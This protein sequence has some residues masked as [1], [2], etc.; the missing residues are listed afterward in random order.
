MDKE[1]KKMAYLISVSSNTRIIKDNFY[2]HTKR[3]F[4]GSLYVHNNNNY[5]TS[6]APISPKRIE[7]SG[8]PITGVGQIRVWI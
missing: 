3:H 6:I 5:K 1:E 8:A 7:F 4:T 2:W